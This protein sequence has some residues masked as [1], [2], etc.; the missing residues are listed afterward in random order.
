MLF[1]CCEQLPKINISPNSKLKIIEEGLF[2]DSSIETFTIP[3]HVSRIGKLA[4]DCCEQLQKIDIL[5]NSE[6][7]VIDDNAFSCSLI[8]CFTF[9]SHIYIKSI[10][11][12][13]FDCCWV[14]QIIYFD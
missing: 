12:F 4:F 9:P 3:N 7:Q 11:Q 14:L 10:G 2:C 1:S 8:R 13:I 6:L 5:P